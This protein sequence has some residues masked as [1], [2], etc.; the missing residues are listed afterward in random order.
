M[1]PVLLAELSLI[2]LL[3]LIT[4]ISG[5]IFLIAGH[6]IQFAGDWDPESASF[7]IYF[8]SFSFGIVSGEG[9]DSQSE[10]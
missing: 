9:W 5:F 8:S 10:I 7:Q 6:S 3:L 1:L 2:L 4:F